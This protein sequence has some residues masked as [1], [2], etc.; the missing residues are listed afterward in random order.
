VVDPPA[1]IKRR[2]DIPQGEAAY[3]KLNQLALRVL[4]DEGL[5]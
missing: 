3:R 5:L 2:K 4:A 1:F